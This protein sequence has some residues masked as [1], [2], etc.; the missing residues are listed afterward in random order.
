MRR[1]AETRWLDEIAGVSWDYSTNLAYLKAYFR[2]YR[3][4]RQ[5]RLVYAYYLSGSWPQFSSE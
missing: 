4:T 1:L 5:R 3:T 2:P